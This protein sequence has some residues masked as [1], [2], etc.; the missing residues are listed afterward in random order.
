LSV[1]VLTADTPVWRVE[2]GQTPRVVVEPGTVV[3]VSTLDCRGGAITSMED[4]W[5]VDRP[6]RI[7]P[8]TGP[9]GVAGAVV[10]DTAI[11]RIDRIELAPQGL[12]LVRPGT[13]TFDFV[14]HG[15]LTFVSVGTDTFTLLGRNLPLRPMIGWVGSQPAEGS[16]D[17]G[18]CGRTG[19]NLDTPLLGPGARVLL[20]IEVPGAAVYIGDVHASQGDGELFLTGIEIGATVTLH[21][22][23][24][25]NLKVHGP[26]VETADVVAVIGPDTGLQASADGACM[27]AVAI[28]Q[29]LTGASAY[30]AGFLLSAACDLRISRYLPGYGS[31]CRLEIPKHVLPDDVLDARGWMRLDLGEIEPRP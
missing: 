5:Q 26:L 21:I 9:I 24:A 11:V 29:T 19:G 25:A 7:N 8:V 23:V 18:S 14:D 1:Q 6:E 31:V 28:L 15:E 27:R 4:R 10:G 30:E 17:T 22:D 16:L 3:E 2:P 12:M 20:P 13:T